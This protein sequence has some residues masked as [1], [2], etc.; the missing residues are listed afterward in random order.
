MNVRT[1]SFLQKWQR[2][3]SSHRVSNVHALGGL[4]ADEGRF[5]AGLPQ[6]DRLESGTDRSRFTAMFVEHDV[7]LTGLPAEVVAD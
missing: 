6:A 1:H 2:V 7:G 3:S 5:V 4:E